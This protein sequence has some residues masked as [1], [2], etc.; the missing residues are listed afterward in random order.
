VTKVNVAGNALVYS[1]YL[2]GSDGD[3][4]E[5]I[6]VDSA[7][8][9][10]LT[11][12]TS[13]TNFPTQ[14]PF[15][16]AMAGPTDAF[17]TKLNAAGNALVYSSYL[18]GSDNDNGG[19]I[20][21]DSAGSAYLTGRTASLNFPTQGPF[22][23]ANA[24]PT[25]AFVTKLNAAGNALI[26]SSYLGGSDPDGGEA[27]AVDSAGS[28]YLTGSTSSTNFPTQSPFQAA[29]G[30]GGEDAFL[31]KIAAAPTAVELRSFAAS[32]S[33]RLVVLRWRTGSELSLLGFHVYRQDDRERLRLT[34]AL[35]RAASDSRGRAYSFR[36]RLPRTSRS[37]RYWLEEVRLDGSRRWHGPIS[38]S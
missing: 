29:Y 22:Q 19:G 3:G 7:G 1:S 5:A 16:A 4:G 20:A 32:R 36:D 38:P 35:I 34:R 2:G 9:A 33:G 24:G 37:P 18:G 17:V 6:A 23:A 21:I 10:Y 28:A 12:A 25:D 30:G 8:S 27:I 31:T 14:G 15:Q 11:G 26:Y 13:S